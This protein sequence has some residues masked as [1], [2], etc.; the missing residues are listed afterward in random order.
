MNLIHPT[1][2][3]SPN[4]KLGENVKI[5]PFTIIHDDVEIGDNTEIASSAVLYDGARIGN[6]VKIFQ[7]A[8]IANKP[9]DLK[10][11]DEKT[12]FYVGDNTTIREF[13]TLHRGTLATGKAS[14]GKD[15]LIMAYAH[16]AHDCIIG[17]NCILSNAVQVGGHVHVGDWVIIGG[18]TAIHQFSKI[19]EHS[20]IGGSFK[21]SS[22]VPPYILA[23]GEP[24]RYHGLNVIGLRRRG[25]SN[26]DI[27][28]IKDCYHFLY[29]SGNNF[30]QAKEK[31]AAKYPDN[32][33][34]K[35]I[36]DFFIDVK[37]AVI[38]R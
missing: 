1:S 30:S 28:T 31:I 4:A 19:G 2:I 34:A 25:F 3:V 16:V 23:A 37:R 36:L 17:D 13:V 27:A 6:N 9:Q 10:F 5:G 8:S 15:C 7:G 11:G 18:L 26:D 14:V 21:V 20:M 24:L 33:Y 38:R 22:D 32:I 35:K 29:H 12:Y